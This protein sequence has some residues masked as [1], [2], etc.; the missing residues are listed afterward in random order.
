VA[1][2]FR[3]ELEGMFGIGASF[4]AWPGFAAHAVDWNCPFL[5]ETGYR[6]FFGVALELQPG[7][8]P[9]TFAAAV[10]TTHVKRHLKGRL[11]VIEPQHR[12]RERAMFIAGDQG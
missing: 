6:S 12:Q 10:I 9:D 5:S 7:F 8:T 3:I 1:C 2:A 11:F 4:M